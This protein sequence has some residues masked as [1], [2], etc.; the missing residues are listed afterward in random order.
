MI[1][2][3]VARGVVIKENVVTCATGIGR[4]TGRNIERFIED[5]MEGFLKCECH[6]TVQ[7]GE[8][9]YER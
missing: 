4:L 3:P 2:C 5:F 1:A 6:L 7:V 8:R 9:E